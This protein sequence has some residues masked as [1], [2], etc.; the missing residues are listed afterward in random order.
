LVAPLNVT[1]AAPDIGFE[2]VGFQIESR[3][4]RITFI[5]LARPFGRSPSSVHRMSLIQV[6]LISGDSDNCKPTSRED[7]RDISCLPSAPAENLS[8]LSI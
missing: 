3:T 7:E 5:R 1:S 2:T 6:K 4:F 8:Q